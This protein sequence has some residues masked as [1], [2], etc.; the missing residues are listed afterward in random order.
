[1]KSQTFVLPLYLARDVGSQL[2][3]GADFEYETP[4]IAVYINYFANVVVEVGGGDGSL[5]NGWDEKGD[6]D[7]FD[8]LPLSLP[9][10]VGSQLSVGA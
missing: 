3:V 10:D 1:M 6:D 9:R 8:V 7:R 5:Y 4:D 2:S